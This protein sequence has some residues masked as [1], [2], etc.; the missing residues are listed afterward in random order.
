MGWPSP[1]GSPCALP[2]PGMASSNFQSR[3]PPSLVSALRSTATTIPFQIKQLASGR[4]NKSRQ[5]K[6]NRAGQQQNQRGDSRIGGASLRQ[7]AH[8]GNPGLVRCLSDTLVTML[9][10]I[11]KCLR[12]SNTYCKQ[13]RT[14]KH[15]LQLATQTHVLYNL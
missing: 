9:F 3:S 8:R 14:T 11:F 1:P 10:L 12:F 6:Q 7:H 4:W 13:F 15:Y 2:P 5:Q